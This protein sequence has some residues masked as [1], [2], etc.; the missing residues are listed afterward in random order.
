MNISEEYCALMK[1]DSRKTVGYVLSKLHKENEKIVVVYADVG[2]R[3]DVKG[4]L[5]D[6]ELEI[7]I[8]EQS[9]IPILGGMAHEGFIPYGIA[10]A[11]FITMRAADQIRMTAGQM[12]LNIILIGG[13]A[14]LVSGN[15]GAASL[16]LDDLSVMRA[17]P[18][19]VIMSPSDS[20]MEAYMIEEAAKLGK[21]VYIR[22]TGNKLSNIYSDYSLFEFG[23]VI[24]LCNYGEDAVIYTTG[25]VTYNV[26]NAAKRLHELNINVTVVDIPYIKPLA[27]TTVERYGKFPI[28]FTVEE[29]SIIGGL[30]SAISELVA[31]NVCQKLVPIGVNDTYLYPDSYPNLLKCVGLDVEGLVER[32]KNTIVEYKTM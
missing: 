28:A 7:G 15:L 30:Y 22:L 4:R 32:I 17:I 27:Y 19:M 25:T 12:A 13:S 18:N 2:S 24:E 23:N 1:L 10:Y 16:A 8:S 31:N 14:G 26:I 3:F 5:N 11:P 20:M 29:H 6:R 21:P 9:L